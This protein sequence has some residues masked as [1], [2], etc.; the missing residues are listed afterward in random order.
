MKILIE[1]GTMP[2]ESFAFFPKIC[3]EL[4][5]KSNYKRKWLIWLEP[6]CK[7]NKNNF[8]YETKAYEEG[9]RDFDLK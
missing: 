7:V 2:N 8:I 1:D 5:V 6:Y 3:I 9:K 4:K